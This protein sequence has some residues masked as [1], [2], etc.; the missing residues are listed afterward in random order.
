MSRLGLTDAQWAKIEPLCHG[1]RSDPGRSGGEAMLLE[2]SCG[3][4]A[5]VARGAIC[6]PIFGTGIR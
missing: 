5:R 2:G 1:K 4:H 6:L 3:L